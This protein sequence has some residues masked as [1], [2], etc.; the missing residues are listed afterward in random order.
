MSRDVCEGSPK[1]QAFSALMQLRN[2]R[3]IICFFR[4]LPDI[5]LNADANGTRCKTS[6]LY[7]VCYIPEALASRV[8]RFEYAECGKIQEHD[9]T[10]F[11]PAGKDTDH[12]SLI[13]SKWE[14]APLSPSFHDLMFAFVESTCRAVVNHFPRAITQHVAT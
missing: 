5:A 10:I 3:R 9:P 11:W 8:K 12:Y 1:K 6:L 7:V 13:T 4:R 2:R 14:P